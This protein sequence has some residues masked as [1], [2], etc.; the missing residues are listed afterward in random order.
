M[1]H[2]RQIR[3]FL[4]TPL[5]RFALFLLLF[6]IIV[7]G[8]VFKKKPQEKSE[9]VERE[10]ATVATHSRFVH[11]IS[12]PSSKQTTPPPSLEHVEPRRNV[13]AGTG[14]SAPVI[15]RSPPSPIPMA[16]FDAAD[17]LP[18]PTRPQQ[19][20]PFGRLIR[21]ELINTV[22]TSNMLTP[23]IGLVTDDVW[24]EGALI[25]PAGTEVHGI[26]SNQPERERIG[27]N[28]H[29]MLVFHDGREL[30][31]SGMALDHAPI[32]DENRWEISDGS[33]G[34]RGNIIPSDRYAE[35]KAVSAAMLA[36]A[37]DG[38]IENVQFYGQ[39]GGTTIRRIPGWRTALA[40]GIE[41]GAQLISQRLL[42]KGDP[43]FVRVPAG[44]TFYLYVTQTVDLQQATIAGSKALVP[45]EHSLH[46]PAS[47]KS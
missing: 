9:I 29:W 6:F 32:P 27:T 39:Y 40:A 20:L 8:G 10:G 16:I 11:P 15:P 23:I 24:Q 4:R 38:L 31:I 36:A 26:A 19:Y 35:T 34:L 2:L 46:L 12:P 45:S 18:A 17:S 30:G 44:T 3:A 21:C 37:A 5:G 42:E 28:N 33:A 25:V 7:N 1:I 22:D 13:S 14:L 41:R 43:F 47:P